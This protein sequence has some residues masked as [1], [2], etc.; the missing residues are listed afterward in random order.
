MFYKHFRP[1]GKAILTMALPDYTTAAVHAAESITLPGCKIVAEAVPDPQG[2]FLDDTEG[3][4]PGQ[5]TGSGPSAGVADGKTVTICGFQG[6]TLTS[7]V[8]PMLKGFRTAEDQKH[9]V[10]LAPMFV[11]SLSYDIILLIFS[12]DL[13]KSSLCCRGSQYFWNPNLKHKDS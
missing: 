5:H 9:P 10:R 4:K 13:I 8:L 1:T 11:L 7:Q 6:K 12:P 3:G 2:L